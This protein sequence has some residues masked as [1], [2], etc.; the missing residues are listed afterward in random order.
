[1]AYTVGLEKTM[2]IALVQMST[3]E[4]KAMNIAKAIQSID[5]V[6][7][8]DTIDMVILPVQM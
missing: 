8:S 1:M 2:K 4:D 6:C 5:N 3:E 7:Q